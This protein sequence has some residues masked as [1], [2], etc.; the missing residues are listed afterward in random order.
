[1]KILVK[2]VIGLLVLLVI[3]G[4]GLTILV[5]YSDP[6]QYKQVFTE[7]FK[8]ATGTDV[9]MKGDFDVSF[10]PGP[11][12]QLNEATF[13]L[14]ADQGPNY[15][16]SVQKLTADMSWASV[17][18]ES[19]SI[20]GLTGTKGTVTIT[21][22]GKD[23]EKYHFDEIFTELKK[24]PNGWNFPSLSVSA[25]KSDIT[26]NLSIA[27]GVEEG[28][29]TK[30]SGKLSSK[31][32]DLASFKEEQKSSMP[33]SNKVIP[34]FDI[35]YETLKELDM[36]LSLTIQ[37]MPLGDT[38]V[39]DITFDLKADNGKAQIHP[40]AASMYGGQLNGTISLIRTK[41]NQGK[42]EADLYGKQWLLEELLISEGNKSGIQQ[43]RFDMQFSGHSWGS[44]LRQVLGEWQGKAH[45]V[46]GNA[47]IQNQKVK[48]DVG[49]VAFGFLSF[50][51]PFTK[52]DPNTHIQCAAMNYTIK[53]GTA[54]A[55]NKVAVETDKIDVL[56]S[57]KV[58][59]KN[60]KID[61]DFTLRKKSG[62]DIP[63]GNF[64]KY[65][66]LEGT[67][68]QPNIVLD[69]K[70]AIQEGISIFSALATGG[71]SLVVDQVFDTLSQEKNPCQ[72]VMTD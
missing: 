26:G 63:M 50:L 64:D 14:P 19:F 34:D 40:I 10:F 15:S 70:G 23:A 2:I 53:N 62:I 27:Q 65:V 44:S 22:K 18:K 7:K 33:N 4:I 36:D 3:V 43:G 6:N 30:V 11:S 20:K 61:F 28:A 32:F 21:E 9:Q 5:M 71:L 52:V 48:G 42:V 66:R 47:V 69:P 56:G 72:S 59:L 57:G 49:D 51:N 37:Q 31:H 17:L 68:G 29:R 12:I 1:M 60:E 25:G 55:M 45:L 41:P 39:K 46:L 67:L 35:P 24:T 38:T 13:H 54:F 8:Q 16:V 58:N